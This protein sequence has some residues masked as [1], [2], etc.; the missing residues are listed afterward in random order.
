[1][2][3]DEEMKAGAKEPMFNQKIFDAAAFET[4]FR[5]YFISMCGYCQYKFGFDHDLAKDTV[6][7]GF[8]KLWET[9]QFIS[10]GLSAKPY[11]NRIIHNI[12]LDIIKHDKV[13]KRVQKD[14]LQTSETIFINNVFENSDSKQLKADI[15]TALSELPEQMR[16]VFELCRYEGLK[17]T[18]VAQQLNV[19]VKTVEAHMSRALV[20]LRDKLSG[21]LVI[22]LCL[23]SGIH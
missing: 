1:M 14:I 6:Q 13:K 15:D 19:S 20:R 7:A 10:P 3:L 4:F 2:S 22:F 23:M 5:K 8:L 9:R 12:C 11:F 17:Y 16:R 18:E 21:Y